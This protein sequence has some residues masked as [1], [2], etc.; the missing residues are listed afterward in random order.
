MKHPIEDPTLFGI[1]IIDELV[2]EHMQLEANGD[3]FSNLAEN[4]DVIGCLGA[5]SDEFD[6]DNLLE[7]QYHS[8]SEDDIDKLVN[9]DINSETVDWIDRVCKDEESECS[10]RARV[11]VD[12]TKKPLQAQ[13]AKIIIA[14]YDLANQGRDR[15]WAE[16]NSNTRVRFCTP[17]LDDDQQF[18]VII[19]NS[20]HREQEEKLF[21]VLREQNKAIWWHLSDLPGINPSIYMH[22]ILMKEEAHPIR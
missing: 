20:L 8:D 2:A 5:V 9:L 6:Y 11:Q 4:I 17:Y 1:D 21:Q 3:E 13:V 16:R 10:N 18:L 19:A 15:T 7:V 22:K 12:K 14:N